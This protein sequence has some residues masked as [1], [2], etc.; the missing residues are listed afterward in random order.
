MQTPE[1][2]VTLIGPSGSGKTSFVKRLLYGYNHIYASE[3]TLGVDVV[4]ID[5]HRNNI[6]IRLNIW[7]CAGDQRYR[8]LREG[9]HIDTN[10][11]I[12]FRKSELQGTRAHEIYENELP[13]NIPKLYID[14]YNLKNPEYTI[15]QYKILLSGLI[16][17]N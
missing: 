13:E 2:K 8:G 16:L 6:K 10:A 5:I 14:D 12:I 7:D 17:N 4:P 11:A 3:T 9:Y 1:F 15:D